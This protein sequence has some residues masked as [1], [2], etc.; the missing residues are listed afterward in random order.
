M[1][2]MNRNRA[3]QTEVEIHRALNTEQ[4]SGELLATALAAALVE[5]RNHVQRCDCLD[6]E[7]TG[8]TGWRLVACWERL[9]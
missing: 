6:L 3:A 7:D 8:G 5:Y 4:E 1:D 9:Q 2:V